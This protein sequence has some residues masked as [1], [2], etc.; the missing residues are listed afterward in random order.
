MIILIII[1]FY[2][3][4]NKRLLKRKTLITRKQREEKPKEKEN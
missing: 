2:I 4:Y 3:K 1:Y